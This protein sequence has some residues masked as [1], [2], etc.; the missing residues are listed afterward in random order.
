MIEDCTETH[1]EEECVENRTLEGTRVSSQVDEVS[2]EDVSESPPYTHYAILLYC[3]EVSLKA[4]VFALESSH[5]L[6]D[7]I[8]YVSIVVF[9]EL[10]G[11][12]VEANFTWC[13]GH[14]DDEISDVGEFTRLDVHSAQIL[15]YFF[16]GALVNLVSIMQ[17]QQSIEKHESIG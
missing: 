15:S 1:R 13:L 6:R 10:S 12:Q 2:V 9:L 17:K 16:G 5:L 8:P 3:C 14:S 7:F 11:C 4:F